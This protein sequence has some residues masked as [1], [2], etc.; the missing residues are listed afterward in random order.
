M[1]FEF[2]A[3]STPLLFGFV[4]GW[5]Y[6]V[7]FWVRAWRQERLSDALFGC[8]LA[9][10]T[11][12]IWEY[13]LG[14]GGI[15]ILW[16]ELEFFP[17]NFN[18]LLPPLAYIYLKSQFNLDYRPVI[19]E[20]KHLTPFLLFAAYHI[21]VF[22]G[23]PEFV[24]YWKDNVHYP[25][26]I[27]IAELAT[28]FAVQLAY[29]YWAY[30]LY[31]N[32]RKW[33]PSQFSD[34][35]SVSFIWFRNFLLAFLASNLISWSMTLIDFWLHLDFWHDWWDELFNAGLI[36]YLSIAG[37]AQLQP[38]KIHYSPQQAI[39]TASATKTDKLGAVDLDNWQKKV[40]TLMWQE[41]IYLDPELTL[42]EMAQRLG[43]NASLLSA[44]INNAFGKNFNDFVNEYR[45]AEVKKMLKNPGSSHLSLLG[46]GLEC[47]FNSKSTFNRAFKKATGVSPRDY[48]GSS[49]DRG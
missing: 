20:I 29:F 12:E 26:G 39:E 35:E 41:K 45:V 11:F 14:F 3:Y 34:T 21:A 36:Y 5:V 1:T 27:D 31:R 48:A 19:S 17:R 15:E 25:W 2:N 46:I 4:Q 43:L 22:T 16:R 42:S 13:M 24:E 9:A 6:A 28:S 23:G 40:E 44:V 47:G 30:R 38:R 10:F 8:L 18:L 33:A 49:S 37:Y 32:Y 7:L